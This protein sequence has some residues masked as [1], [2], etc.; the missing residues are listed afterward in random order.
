[1]I[2]Q[3]QIAFVTRQRVGLVRFQDIQ[4]HLIRRSPLNVNRSI[5]DF[6]WI[7]RWLSRLLVLLPTASPESRW[8]YDA[9]AFIDD[10]FHQF[11]R[12]FVGCATSVSGTD[13]MIISENTGQF[14]IDADALNPVFIRSHSSALRI[15]RSRWWRRSFAEIV[16]NVA[17][18]AK[19]IQCRN[20][21]LAIGS[22]PDAHVER[23]P[24]RSFLWRI[25]TTHVRSRL[26]SGRKLLSRKS[27]DTC[28]SKNAGQRSR[29]TETIRQHVFGAGFAELFSE[30]IIAV[31]DLSDDGFSV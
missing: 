27:F 8:V 20:H 1:M 17:P 28:V 21:C 15:S 5:A 31:E 9:G 23:N 29:K 13:V 19:R 12:I 18:I 2:D 7:R 14:A 16:G 30:V 3:L 24:F 25:R 4:E 11:D 26:P 22:F 6:D 10:L